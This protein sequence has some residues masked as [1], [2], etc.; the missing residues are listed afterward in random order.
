[1]QHG[2][3]ELHAAKEDGHAPWVDAKRTFQLKSRGMKIA[4]A[5]LT[6]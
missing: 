4:T 2:V 3:G 5:M 1:M 6:T